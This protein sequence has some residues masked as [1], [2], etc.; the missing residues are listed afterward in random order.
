VLATVFTE[1]GGFASPDA[2]VDGLIPAV[3]V[4]SAVLAVGALVALLVPGRRGS[5]AAVAP[6]NGGLVTEPAA[7]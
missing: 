2:Y 7:A 4:A 6:A 1:S 3:W 5:A